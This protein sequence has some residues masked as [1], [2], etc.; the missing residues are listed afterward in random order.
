MKPTIWQVLR[1]DGAR[2]KHWTVRL[3]PAGGKAITRGGYHTKPEAKAAAFLMT[4]ALERGDTDY[5][6]QTR[7]RNVD[8]LGDLLEAW[9]AAGCPGRKGDRTGRALADQQHHVNGPLQWWADQSASA[10]TDADRRAYCAHRAT[11]VKRGTGGGRTSERELGSL[12]DALHWGWR[13]GALKELPREMRV[14][15]RDPSTI[16]HARDAMPTGAAELHSLAGWLFSHNRAVYGWMVLFEAYT[17]MRK[18]EC[19]RLLA[20]PKRVGHDYPAGYA[21]EQWLRIK[22]S[23]GGGNPKI[24]LDDPTRPHI[25]PLLTMIRN[26]H[27]A[28]AP[29]NPYLFPGPWG[30]TATRLTRELQAA[31]T[32][33]GLP[34]RRGHSLRAYYASVRL[35]QGQPPETVARELGQRSGDD[36]VRDVYGVDPDDYDAAQWTTMADRFTWLPPGDQPPAWAWW[37]ETQKKVI[38][39]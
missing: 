19:L 23:K 36:L 20:D 25:R 28:T 3:E 24:A 31:A 37:T 9:Q 35:A 22:R 26:W 7:R 21:D 8:R 34:K 30:G 12:N 29:T 27:A 15:F 6:E 10:I 2:D 17:G 33:L 39:L 11:T 18:S 32:A 16:A 1:R 4:A 14:T 13:T 5:I 38:V